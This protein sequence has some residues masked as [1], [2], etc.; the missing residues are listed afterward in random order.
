MNNRL[1]RDFNVKHINIFGF[2]LALL[3]FFQFLSDIVIISQNEVFEIMKIIV[4][5]FYMLFYRKNI[6]KSF[7]I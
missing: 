5:C 6:L 7:S 3:S 2:C 1:L 4:Y